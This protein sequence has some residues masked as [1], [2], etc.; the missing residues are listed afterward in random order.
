LQDNITGIILA[1][2][3]AKR[4]SHTDK[5][6]LEFRGQTLL[7]RRVA[8]LKPLC[9]EIIVVS[10]S[11]NTYRAEGFR[12][13]KDV[14]EG[15]GPLMGLYSGL[16]SSKTQRCFVTACDMPFLKRE[17]FDCLKSY[18][19]TW[20]SVIPR[21]GEYVEPLFSFYS[22]RCLAAIEKAL[23]QKLRRIVSFFDSVKIRYVEEAEIRKHDRE[24][25]SF[26][27][28]NT[29]QDLRNAERLAKQLDA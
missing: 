26:R 6:L 24:L 25:L 27:N 2:G 10:N 20:D 15:I 4:L 29:I 21:I 11:T 16:A 19:K 3:K 23:S 8:L 7:E 22:V 17:L 18:S 28:I 12:V 9:R 13:V 14:E 1:G 5:A